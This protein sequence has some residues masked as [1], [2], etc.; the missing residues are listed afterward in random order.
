[1]ARVRSLNFLTYYILSH[2]HETKNEFH[3]RRRGIALL[4]LSSGTFNS[5]E[6]KLV[7]FSAPVS[8][9]TIR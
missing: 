1:M 8:A 5:N 6:R 3:Y 9:D 7:E 4:L 2:T